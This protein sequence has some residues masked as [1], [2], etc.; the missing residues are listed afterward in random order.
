MPEET[1]YGWGGGR[2]ILDSKF[3]F[4]RNVFADALHF[5]LRIDTNKVPGKLKKAYRMMEE[6]ATAAANPSGFI[7]K[8]QKRETK[9]SVRRQLDQELRSGKVKGVPLEEVRRKIEGRFES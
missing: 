3:S 4:E 9:E 2:H 5:A 6:E 7:S 1:E 8:S